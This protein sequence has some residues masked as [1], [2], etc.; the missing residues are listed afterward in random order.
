ML[1]LLVGSL[2]DMFPRVGY[3]GVE[4]FKVVGKLRARDCS[5]FGMLWG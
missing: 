5:S 3:R 4:E 1:G 2:I